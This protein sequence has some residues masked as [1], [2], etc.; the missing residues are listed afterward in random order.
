VITYVER[1]TTAIAHEKAVA[2]WL[3]QQGWLVQDFGQGLFNGVMRER[4]RDYRSTDGRKHRLRWLPD[5]LIARKTPRGNGQTFALIEAKFT[6]RTD[7]GKLD[8]LV[9]LAAA[10]TVT[11]M[12]P[13]GTVVAV[14]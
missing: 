9:A 5:L 11:V 14:V 7:T 4:L 13:T 8:G 10:G 1:S 6:G 2:D 3:W 12:N